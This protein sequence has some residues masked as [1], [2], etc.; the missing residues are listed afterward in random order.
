ME[1]IVIVRGLASYMRTLSE[2]AEAVGGLHMTRLVLLLRMMA[3]DLD[4]WAAASPEND[5]IRG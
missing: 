1:F 5:E 4:E 3:A 2:A